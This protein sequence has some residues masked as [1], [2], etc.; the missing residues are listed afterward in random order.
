MLTRRYQARDIQT[1]LDLVKKDLGPDAIIFSINKVND[2]NFLETTEVV[3]GKDYPSKKIDEASSLIKLKEDLEFIKSIF[4]QFLS[5]CEENIKTNK[6]L[7]NIYSRFVAYGIDES[8]IS[9]F[10]KKIEYKKEALISTIL[11]HLKDSIRVIDLCS[12]KHSKIW[13]FIGPTGVGK[14]TTIAKLATRFALEGRKLAVAAAG[15]FRIGTIEQL[16]GY[17]D[18]IGMCFECISKPELLKRFIENHKNKDFILIDTPGGNPNDLIYLNQLK[19]ILMAHPFIEKHLVLSATTKEKDLSR[20]YSQFTI[21]PIKS[22]VFTKIDETQE[23]S[24]IFNQLIKTHIPVSWIGIG[25]RV[26]QDIEKASKAKIASLI[27][28][29]ILDAGKTKLSIQK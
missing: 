23:Y 4:I 29:N 21:F 17:T 18:I 15:S 19:E 8:W 11:S 22:Y 13:A 20:I 7:F 28:D 3:A 16:K 14:T 1:A 10:I 5:N 24:G 6:D 9:K 12:Q 25:Q 27:L 2:S 26:P